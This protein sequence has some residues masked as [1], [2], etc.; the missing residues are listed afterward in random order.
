MLKVNPEVFIR[1]TIT[2]TQY[3]LKIM[4]RYQWSIAVDRNQN[5]RNQKTYLP[6]IV[7]C[8][9][10]YK[11]QWNKNYGRMAMTRDKD[12]LAVLYMM[13]TLIYVYF[14]EDIFAETTGKY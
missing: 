6:R 2:W 4:S 5:Q 9:A 14:Q 11:S 3:P 10:V 13:V 8:W 7:L 12:Y 1:K